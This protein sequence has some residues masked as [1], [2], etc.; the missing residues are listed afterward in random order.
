MQKITPKLK[1]ICETQ[2]TVE[3]ILRF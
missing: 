3:T 2:H 1:T